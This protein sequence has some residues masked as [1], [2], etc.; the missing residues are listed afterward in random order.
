MFR[1]R[2]RRTNLELMRESVYPRAGFWRAFQY[3]AHRL[4]RLPDEPH[5]IAR[6]IFAGVF[7]S[8]TPLFGLHLMLAALL[9]WLLRGNILAALL[10]TFFGNPLTTPVIAYTSVRLGH[11]LLGIDAPV[12]VLSIIAAFGNAGSELW[13]NFR[14]I[15]T[16]DVTQWSSLAAFFHTIFW[17]YLVG[18]LLPG[19]AV[20][21]AVYW[22]S[23][24]VARA[25]QEIRAAKARTRLAERV[26]AKADAGLPGGAHPGDDAG[27]A[28]P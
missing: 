8:F 28:A 17:P 3:V 24:P 4:R 9:A 5:R 6:G 27:R 22:A 11:R 14:A 19:L 16:T 20:G 2:N 12:D 7:V 1:R 25:Y 13:H 10:A 18:G 26:K 21:L 23:I 15:F